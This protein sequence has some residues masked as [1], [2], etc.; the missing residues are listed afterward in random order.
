M[1]FAETFTMGVIRRRTAWAYVNAHG[2]KRRTEQHG[3]ACS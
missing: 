1:T 3:H 2:M